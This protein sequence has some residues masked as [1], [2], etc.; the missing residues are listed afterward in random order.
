MLTGLPDD[1]DIRLASKAIGLCTNEREVILA[2]HSSLSYDGLVIATGA[3]AR[4]LAR[5]DQPGEYVVRCLQDATDLAE[6]LPLITSA[7]V[8]GGGFLGMEIAST[9]I[10]CGITV[11]VVTHRPPL[12]Q[13]LGTWLSSYIVE[14]AKEAGV[15]FTVTDG[16]V[17]LNGTPV[18]GVR[19]GDG[20]LLS[21]D[22]VIS[23]V[24]DIANTEWLAESGLRIEGG[25]NVDEHCL[26]APGIVAA[27]DV[28]IREMPSGVLMRTPHWSNAIV[29]AR[30]AALSLLDP[31]SY[32]HTPD[33]YFWTEQFG[34]DVKIAG[35]LPL[36][37]EPFEARE[38]PAGRSMLLNWLE[39]DMTTAVAAMNY[40]I[41]VARMRAMV[42]S[43]H[44]PE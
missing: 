31:H 13:L 39:G 18:S 5:P 32:T 1:V 23:A 29:Q 12:S 14:V 25:V 41:P 15:R 35:E 16:P 33:H 19:L 10:D 27:G 6:K 44:A 9:L 30:T 24:G 38:K 7:I 3:R 8:I 20:T 21:A 40:R 26:A 28:A 36:N 11:T 43:T 4:R 37:G 17:E 34:L 2:D 22:L 42:G